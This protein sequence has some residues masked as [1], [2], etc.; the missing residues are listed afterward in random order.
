MCSSLD[1]LSLPDAPDSRS[2]HTEIRM[3]GGRARAAGSH[4][5]AAGQ[6]ARCRSGRSRRP[7]RRAGRRSES[8]RRT[9]ARAACLSWCDLRQPVRSR[10][11]PLG[12]APVAAPAAPAARLIVAGRRPAVDARAGSLAAGLQGRGA[13]RLSGCAPLARP[14]ARAGRAVAAAGAQPGADTLQP[15]PGIAV[16][17]DHLPADPLRWTIGGRR[18]RAGQAAKIGYLG[19]SDRFDLKRAKHIQCTIGGGMPRRTA[20]RRSAAATSA[21]VAPIRS[22][23]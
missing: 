12:A 8:T 22:V 6:G 1:F 5:P 9:A 2:H 14:P 4:G 19:E 17:R 20:A 16:R 23:A 10:A 18:C 11:P 7:A 3:S 13:L 21:D 15:D